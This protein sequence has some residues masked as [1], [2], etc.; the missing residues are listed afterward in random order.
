MGHL[1]SRL[2]AAF[3]E[4]IMKKKKKN[5]KKEGGKIRRDRAPSGE[6]NSSPEFS[7][8]HSGDGFYRGLGDRHAELDP[9][10]GQA[11]GGSFCLN[12]S[13]LPSPLQS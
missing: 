9:G 13:A 11:R 1:V 8:V 6:S 10:W 5:G 2:S 7:T 3:M 12:L 4:T